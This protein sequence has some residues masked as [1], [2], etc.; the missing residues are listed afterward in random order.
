MV[1]IFCIHL[2]GKLPISNVLQKISP[3]LSKRSR[4]MKKP[5]KTRADR[6]DQVMA[7]IGTLKKAVGHLATLK[8]KN[9]EAKS[10]NLLSKSGEEGRKNTVG[11]N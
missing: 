9:L 8:I 4:R 3:S 2:T 1:K 6:I 10:R 11:E 5:D 7:H